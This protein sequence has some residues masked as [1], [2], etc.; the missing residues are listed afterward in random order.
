MNIIELNNICR[1]FRNGSLAI[2]ALRQIN[3]TISA[4]EMIAIT[5]PS[6]SGKS[7]LMNILGCLDSADY[8]DYVLRG[9]NIARQPADFLARVRREHI[10]FIFQRYHLIP[11]LTVLEN[12]EIPAIYAGVNRTQR[13]T[14]ATQRLAQ[15][16]LQGYQ[17]HKPGQLSGG[18]QQR[19]SI[20]RALMN[21]AEIILADEPTG[22]LDS[23]AGQEVL[24]I[25]AQLNQ[26]GH[27]V[28][29][30]THDIQVAQRAGRIIELKDGEMIADSGA[31]V[32]IPPPVGMLKTLLPGNTRA[33]FIAR[34]TEPL[35]MALRAMNVHRLRTALTMVGILFGIAAVVTVVALG[36][37]ARQTTLE[38]IQ[39]LGASTVSI[40]P[41]QDYATDNHN[42]VQSLTPSD[43][44][45][46]M[47]QPFIDSISP[48]IHTTLPV[49]YQ[50]Q[51]SSATV[52]GVGQDW[53]HIQGIRLPEGRNFS[54]G[55][56]AG[57]E[58][59]I[60]INTRNLLFGPRSDVA[61]GKIILLGA[62]PVTVVGVANNETGAAANR[63]N[64]WVPWRTVMYRMTGQLSLSSISI[65]LKQHIASDNAVA[66]ISQLLIQ[67]HGSKDFMIFNRDKVRKS[68]ERA[69][70]TLN[71][72]ILSV[73]S[74]SLLIASI[75]VMNIMLVSVTERTHEI[76]VRMAVGARRS[77]IMRQFLLEAVLIC[78]I[79]GGL[80][81]A[82]SLL[83]GAA[84]AGSDNDT[85]RVI[86]STQ[87]ATIA[88]MC[89][90]LTGVLFGYL[91]ARKAA[92]MDPVAA[93][94]SE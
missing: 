40:Y 45:A 72:L 6:G 69:T 15:L 23:R 54:S 58:A 94:T 41:G 57:L 85:L 8:G 81:I 29:I 10:G 42:P 91:P 44:G 84:L 70:A 34:L 26:R 24:N 60:D 83:P 75:G 52:Q 39:D 1:T 33:S 14:M 37:G 35:S 2:Q 65:R 4:G 31:P 28:I 90:T 21:G 17:H 67:R 47:R 27:T 50:A 55:D 30:V 13:Q 73:A 86:W 38:S 11:S 79:G 9:Q 7:T 3:L 80:G 12:V 25:L 48:E 16:G 71:L 51:S 32:A 46:L 19:V 76:G 36:Q 18:Q 87:A 22:A 61:T 89:S 77:D 93:L 68:I 66:L 82:L 5:G 74:V 43:A 20:A 56:D 62:V 49:R 88:F 92:R 53:L 63:L 59:I 78:L 64:V